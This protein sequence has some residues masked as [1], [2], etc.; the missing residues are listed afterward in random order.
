MQLA[1]MS[2]EQQIKNN[3]QEEKIKNFMNQLTGKRF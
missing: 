1:N 2:V 3:L